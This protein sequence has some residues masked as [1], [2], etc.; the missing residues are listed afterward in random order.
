MFKKL[1]LKHSK[2]LNELGGDYLELIV[3]EVDLT[4]HNIVKDNEREGKYEMQRMFI[5]GNGMDKRDGV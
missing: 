3:E 5:N 4:L 1:L 2:R